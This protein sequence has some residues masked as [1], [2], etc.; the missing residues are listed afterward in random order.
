MR[1]HKLERATI[2]VLCQELRLGL[3]KHEACPLVGINRRTLLR[4]RQRHE[5]VRD[6]VQQAE[7]AGREKRRFRYWLRHHNRGKRFWRG[8]EP[9]KTPKYRAPHRREQFKA[10]HGIAYRDLVK[11]VCGR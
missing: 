2:E 3:P 9:S 8:W 6:A 1:P 10:V 7:E 11:K 4:W 5:W